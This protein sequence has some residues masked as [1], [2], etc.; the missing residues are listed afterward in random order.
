MVDG[1]HHAACGRAGVKR[2]SSRPLSSMN[3]SA[4][5][6]PNTVNWSSTPM[7]V[8]DAARPAQREEHRHR[9]R[10][11]QRE[12]AAS[13]PGED[14]PLGGAERRAADQAHQGERAEVGVV[15]DQ[16][17]AGR[18]P[19]GV[20][21][22][23]GADPGCRAPERAL[24]GPPLD[25]AEPGSGERAADQRGVDGVHGSAD[26]PADEPRDGNETATAIHRQPGNARCLD[27][28]CEETV[29]MG[30]PLSLRW[31]GASDRPA[32]R[33]LRLTRRAARPPTN[34][35]YAQW[36]P[37]T[38]RVVPAA[39]RADREYSAGPRWTPRTR[40]RRVDLFSSKPRMRSRGGR[41]NWGTRPTGASTCAV[42]GGRA[43]ICRSSNP[44]GRP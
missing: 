24:G 39:T 23:A 15:A 22:G 40:K 26:R 37:H 29:G 41:P 3:S 5:P 27:G 32:P 33:W 2:A 4:P 6:A 9:Q 14:E 43:T 44:G 31:G 38:N 25:G 21:D 20:A 11:R 12:R 8:T 36:R 17:G 34:P 30:A 35:P 13:L 10:P 1:V 28:C 16:R 42:P 18:Q 19:D 7:P